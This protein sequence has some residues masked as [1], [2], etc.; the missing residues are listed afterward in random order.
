MSM[1]SLL[2]RFIERAAGVRIIRG[3]P[4]GISPF[5]DIARAFPAFEIKIIFDVGANVGQSAT[6]YSSQ[7]PAAQIICFEPV[8][9]SFSSLQGCVSGRH[10]VTCRRL[11]LADFVGTSVMSSEGTSQKNRLLVGG[12]G[13]GTPGV[14]V[15]DVTTLDTYCGEQGIDRIDFLKIDTEGADL[16]V[17][18]GAARLLGSQAIAFIQVEAG[19]N[20]KNQLHVPLESF[21]E[22]LE[23]S[24][25]FLFGIYEQ[26]N[27]WPTRSPHLRRTN[28]IFVSSRLIESV[29]GATA[30]GS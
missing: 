5:E 21:K 26:V 24:D 27:E 23:Q 11:G 22:F 25:Y 1:R 14:E 17:L 29:R 16:A 13:S 30:R 28:P 4:R 18:K 10:N 2:K 3:L 7:F 12:G 6:H 19:M 8:A 9:A 15:V 20:P